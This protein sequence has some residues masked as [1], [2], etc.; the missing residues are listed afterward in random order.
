MGIHIALPEKLLEL[1]NYDSRY[2]LNIFD[3]IDQERETTFDED[4]L[5]AL[6]ARLTSNPNS[7][8]ESFY[9]NYQQWLSYL[10]L[11]VLRIELEVGVIIQHPEANEAAGKII[12][13]LKQVG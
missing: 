5:T 10:T 13:S 11:A 12:E 8:S 1:K 4:S 6:F 3:T 2:V 7:L 9:S